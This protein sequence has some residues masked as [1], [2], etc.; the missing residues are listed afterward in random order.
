MSG[1]LKVGDVD[2][3]HLR[4]AYVEGDDGKKRG[5]FITKEALS[6]LEIDKLM[7]D[8]GRMTCVRAGEAGFCYTGN[9]QL[10][11]VSKVD[12]TAGSEY[13]LYP[14]Y[15]GEEMILERVYD[16]S[17]LSVGVVD[18]KEQ[19]IRFD[20]L[21]DGV[22]ASEFVGGYLIYR[23]EKL[24]AFFP[25]VERALPKMLQ[26]PN[27]LGGSADDLAYIIGL[28]GQTRRHPPLHAL[29]FSMATTA[30]TLMEHNLRGLGL[31]LDE[32]V[33]SRNMDRNVQMALTG[34]VAQTRTTGT[35]LKRLLE[36]ES[37]EAAREV[38]FQDDILKL[39]AY[40]LPDRYAAAL[41]AE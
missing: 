5:R 1:P 41:N 23:R 15:P 40:S 6:P 20:H 13:D 22:T 9:L 35:T 30:V 17:F 39:L 12:M 2:T 27:S 29:L 34:M 24:V 26:R 21:D 3:I 38:P 28:L 4:M 7:G 19:I 14:Y 31:R 25:D 36:R 33:L 37:M 10:I 8:F 18:V 32:V 11:G 16:C